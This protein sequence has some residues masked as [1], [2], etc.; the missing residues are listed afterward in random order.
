MAFAKGSL[1]VPLKIFTR[2]LIQVNSAYFR[3]FQLKKENRRSRRKNCK[4]TLTTNKSGA[5]EFLHSEYH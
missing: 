4:T 5:S 2:Q 1:A 3:L